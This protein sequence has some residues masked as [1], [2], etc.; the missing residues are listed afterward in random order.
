MATKKKISKTGFSIPEWDLI[1]VTSKPFTKNGVKYT[2][3]R[4]LKNAL[5]YIHQE[6]DIKKLSA[7]FQKYCLKNFDKDE[8]KLL[9]LLPDF[10]F[11][12]IAK[13]AYV[14][15]RGGK[16]SDAHAESIKQYYER[17]VEK[18]KLIDQAT[19][20]AEEEVKP[21]GPTI[22]I[23]QRMADQVAPMCSEWDN[24]LDS[25]VT[26]V[27][28]VKDFDP[29]NSMKVEEKQIKA[30]HAKIIKDMYAKDLA[31]AQEVMEWA[32][33]DIKEAYRHMGTAKKRKDFFTFFEKISVACDTVINENKATRK[34]RVKKAPSKQ[35][36]IAK[37]KYKESEASLGIA[38]INPIG[39]IDSK[40]LWV[41]NTKTRKLGCY[42]A[43]EYQGPLSIKG[44]SITGFDA[45]KSICKTVRKPEEL[46]KGAGKL[47]RTKFDKLFSELTTTETKMNGR[48]NE[49]TILIKTF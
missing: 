35:K 43:D 14:A 25:M 4:L 38:S 29:Y 10:D 7:E 24:F 47:A 41:Y 13:Y 17:F 42:V 18:A 34:V 40:A 9:K 39:I 36:L 33:E 8:V 19:N 11:F 45:T 48:L 15:N 46:L 1:D 2:Y 26:G 37:L 6:V 44:T 3:D 49:H 16:L 32:D 22:S 21:A 5:W 31:E 23:Q 28:N 20:E 12:A 30:A 27:A